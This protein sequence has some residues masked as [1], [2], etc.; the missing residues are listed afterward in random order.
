MARESEVRFARLSWNVLGP[1][2]W[3]VR[4]FWGR[5][6]ASDDVTGAW[7]VGMGYNGLG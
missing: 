7:G 5:A 3:G 4:A 2:G 1:P 6:H